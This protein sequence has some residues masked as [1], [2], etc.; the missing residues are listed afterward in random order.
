MIN[1]SAQ[2]TSKTKGKIL[3]INQSLSRL[4]FSRSKKRALYERE[5]I[6][7]KLRSQLADSMRFKTRN[8][9]IRVE[10]FSST[11]LLKADRKSRQS[12]KLDRQKMP[13]KRKDKILT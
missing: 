7:S 6:P 4:S 2:A 12:G 13:N 5:K 11:L 10:I 9:S 8:Y 1:R 3:S